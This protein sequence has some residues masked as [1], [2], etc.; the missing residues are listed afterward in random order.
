MLVQASFGNQ[1]AFIHWTTDIIYTLNA[2]EDQFD[3][4]PPIPS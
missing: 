1:L 2:K 3:P 4:W